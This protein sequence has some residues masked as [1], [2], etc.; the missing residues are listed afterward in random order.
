[1]THQ[2][3]DSSKKAE[4]ARRDSTKELF[5]A[6]RQRATEVWVSAG[7]MFHLVR[8]PLTSA[9]LAWWAQ[10]ATYKDHQPYQE[11]AQFRRQFE[12]KDGVDY[13]WVLEYAKESYDRLERTYRYLDEKADAIIKYLGGG[14]ALVTLGALASGN[15]P[16]VL[17]S[18]LFLP[19][20]LCAILAVLFAAVARLPTFHPSPP[21][22]KS[23]I[24]YA[25]AFGEKA[26]KYV[27]A[28]LHE[29]C[30]GLEPVND[31]KA[32]KVKLASRFYLYALVALLGA[33]VIG[34]VFYVF[35]PTSVTTTR[36]EI[37][38]PEPKR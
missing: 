18:A 34:T 37:V 21:R 30:E 31:A 23:M 19:F 25:E 3:R 1:M 38:N 17:V 24:E 5:D 2:S 29:C 12:P 33:L 7:Q 27:I 32:R 35:T 10:A 36:I 26:E 13:K 8:R 11:A 16:S 28:N 9:W 4:K 6:V 20:L 22:V 14:T 15:R